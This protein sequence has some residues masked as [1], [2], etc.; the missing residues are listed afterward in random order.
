MVEKATS[1]RGEEAEE[2]AKVVRV[3]AGGGFSMAVFSNGSVYAW[4]KRAN[5]RLGVGPPPVVG[6]RRNPS[7]FALFPTKLTSLWDRGVRVA[8]VGETTRREARVLT[9]CHENSEL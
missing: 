4:G 5:G 3:A 7:R 6:E 9:Y 8:Q 2:K 1:L